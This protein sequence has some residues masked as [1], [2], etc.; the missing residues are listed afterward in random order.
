MYNGNLYLDATTFTAFSIDTSLVNTNIT[1]PFTNFN[2]T[3]V[4]G[5]LNSLF[6]NASYTQNATDTTKTDV[7]LTLSS[8]A[9][10]SLV[11]NSVTSSIQGTHGG[12]TQGVLGQTLLELMALGLFGHTGTRAAISNDTSFMTLDINN[13]SITN[14]TL[15]NAISNAI[16]TTLN[17]D[18][19][20]IFNQYTATP[21]YTDL[22]D[23]NNVINF[24]FA[25]A[26]LTIPLYMTGV[27]KV[28]S[29]NTTFSGPTINYINSAGSTVG[30]QFV[31]NG[32]YNI[33]VTLLFPAV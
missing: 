1:A 8:T 32:A 23:A 29:T 28:G 12:W 14:T 9:I 31:E 2:I 25:G 24:N 22:D 20:N 6:N 21:Q 13:N 5:A 19:N 26:V 15:A 3:F 10:S 33:A 7:T 11:V 27:V 4:N 17:A 30:A 18:K 16:N